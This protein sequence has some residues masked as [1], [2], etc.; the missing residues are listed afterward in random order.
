MERLRHDD[1]TQIGPYVTLARLD[2]ESAGP[3]ERRYL[4]RTTDGERTVL[5]CVPRVGADPSRWALEA[6]GARRLSVPGFLTVAEV[7][8]TAGFPWYA[9]PYTPALPLPAVLAAHGG[10]LPEETVRG[11]GAAL[12]RT[13]AA[14]HAQ[15]VT[16]AG[17]S[18][19]A[20]LITPTGPLLTCFGATRASLT[21]HDPGCL[22]PEQAAGAAP[23]PA[24][25][26]Y[27]L[28]AVVAYAATGH[29][30]PEQSE[31]PQALRRLTA[32]CLARVPADRPGTA[33]EV[34]R[35]LAAPAEHTGPARAPR[36]PAAAL[37]APPPLPAATVLDPAA[38][39]PLPG[40]VV[41]ALAA[42]SGALMAME[43]PSSQQSFTPISQKVH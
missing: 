22:A 6:E 25:D 37:P 28:G 1:P 9:A 41:A 40:R 14:A 15:G 27:A 38:P 39:L 3:A 29:T 12:A 10:P 31:L 33:H 32:S 17:L 42:Q 34:L 11:L 7:G 23:E 5:V 21:G 8:G 19:T 36:L 35:E 43:L 30:V 26:L 2:A 13:L 20:V 4:A 18:P 24:G 16:H